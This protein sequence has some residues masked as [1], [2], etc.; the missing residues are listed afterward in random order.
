VFAWSRR[1]HRWMHWIAGATVVGLMLMT[2]ADV[3]GRRFFGSPVRG[4]VELTQLAMVVMIYLGFAY[5]E[6]HGDHI[7]VD[8][9]YLRLRRWLQ[10]VITALTS[11]FGIAVIGLLAYRLYLYSGV[12]A[13]GGYTTPTRGIS[14][15]PFA[16]I[17]VGG[18]ALFAVAMADS[19][20]GA[21][22][23]F[24]ERS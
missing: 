21:L 6:N 18:A 15:A 12:L 19:A 13:G 4:S 16:L 23:R 10:L 8:I 7:S 9:V 1:A 2:V 14:Q 17:A 20:I 3:V 24:R 22:G 11:V 5:A